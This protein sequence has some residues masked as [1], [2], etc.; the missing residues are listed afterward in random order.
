MKNHAAEILKA[1]GIGLEKWNEGTTPCVLKPLLLTAQMLE[2]MF[3]LP[4]MWL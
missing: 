1:T 2:G 3:E 4:T